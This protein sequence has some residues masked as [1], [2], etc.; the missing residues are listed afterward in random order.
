MPSMALTAPLPAVQ[1]CSRGT[2]AA[3]CGQGSLSSALGSLEGL[4]ELRATQSQMIWGP[5]QP[6]AVLPEAREG[7][8]VELEPAIWLLAACCSHPSGSGHQGAPPAKSC[9][10]QLRLRSGGW[11]SQGACGC[12]P[13][14]GSVSGIL[15]GAQVAP[16]SSVPSQGS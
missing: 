9:L 16:G 7:R 3:F 1:A 11:A 10:Q 12:W 14:H 2:S 4:G 6:G 8:S 13:R 15:S 5:L